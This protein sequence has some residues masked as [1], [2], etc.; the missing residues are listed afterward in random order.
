MDSIPDIPILKEYFCNERYPIIIQLLV[1]FAFGV[2][3]SPYSSGIFWLALS[4]I[5]YEIIYMVCSKCDSRYWYIGNRVSII[6]AGFL[7]WIIGREFSGFNVTE[8]GTPNFLIFNKKEIKE[9]DDSI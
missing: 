6:F 2:A 8:E 7:G 3:F 9:K 1:S 5:I 4:I